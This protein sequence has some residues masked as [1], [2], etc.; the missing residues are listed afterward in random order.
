LLE[1]FGYDAIGLEYSQKAVEACEKYV[2]EHGSSYPVRDEKI[3]KGSKKFV[4]VDFYKDNWLSETGLGVKHFDLIYD[5]TFF[6]A[7]DPSMR[8]QWALR[9]A[10][11]LGPSPQGNLICLE[12]PTTKEA[13][14]GGP[15]FSSPP[16]AYMEHLSHPGEQVPYD[17]EG[18]V[19]WNPLAEASPQGLE[20]VAHFNPKDAH[21]I[22][23]DD[24][25][26]VR[27]FV[28]I[29]RHR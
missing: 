3:G 28:A 11:L 16:K 4:Q 12:F 29:W 23:K 21:S 19:K 2:D 18:N 26:N 20:R 8:P 17:S 15:P 7:M 9:M 1:S 27:D 5:F 13:S 14:A 25:G 24:Q 22:G 6:C 10:Q